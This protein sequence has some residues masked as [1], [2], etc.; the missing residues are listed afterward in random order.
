MDF[1]T[2]HYLLQVQNCYKIKK[3]SSSGPKSPVAPKK[4]AWPQRQPPPPS[5]FVASSETVKEAAE[6]AAYRIA[7]AESK[8]YLAAEAVKEAE[9]IAWL[10]ESSESMLQLAQQIYEHCTT[11]KQSYLLISEFSNC[12]IL[13]YNH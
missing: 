8:S 11:D 3:D 9:R 6:T 4:D 2:H 12:M 13:K 5:D 1:S 7:D 10:A